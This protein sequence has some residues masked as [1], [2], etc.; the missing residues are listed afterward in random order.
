MRRQMR[1]CV[2]WIVGT[3]LAAGAQDHVVQD[4]CQQHLRAAT[5]EAAQGNFSAA[6]ADIQ[7]A[8]ALEPNGVAGWYQLGSLLGQDGDFAGAEAALRHAI[9]LEPGLAKAHY[10]LALALVGNPQG[11]QDWAGAISE[12]RDALK[13]K[14]DYAEALNLLGAGLNHTGQPAE[15]VPV[16]EQAIRLNPGLS[17]AHFNLALALES[18]ALQ[19]QAAPSG[20]PDDRL[21]RAAREY[22]AAITARGAYPEA[23]SALAKLHLQMGKTAQAE[24]EVDTALRLNPD[25]ADAHYTLARILRSQKRNKEAEIEFAQVKDLQERQPDGIQSSHLSNSALQLASQDDLKGAVAML[26]KAILLKPDYGV[27]HY[28]LGLVLAD[29]GDFSGAEQELTKAISL[30]PGQPKPWFELGRVE[31]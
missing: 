8:I 11:K 6:M 13:L 28:N 21:E 14:P 25:L 24:E 7:A 22:Q 29:T 17:E 10:G 19:S 27:P 31:E 23:S 9:K 5:D 15:A 30:L 2:I 26:K 18:L 16:L 20:P 12:C 1:Q 4:A 3:G